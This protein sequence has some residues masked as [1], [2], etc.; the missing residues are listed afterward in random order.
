MTEP[1][2][3]MFFL[4]FQVALLV[5]HIFKFMFHANLFFL[6]STPNPDQV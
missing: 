2:N 4:S 1:F 6:D 5:F 3:K